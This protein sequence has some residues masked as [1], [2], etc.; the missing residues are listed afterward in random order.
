MN[1]AAGVRVVVANPSPPTVK[2]RAG[3][4]VPVVAVPASGVPTVIVSSPL[5]DDTNIPDLV[6]LYQA[7]AN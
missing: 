3:N 7:A 1:L 5:R 2:V 4:A 6:A